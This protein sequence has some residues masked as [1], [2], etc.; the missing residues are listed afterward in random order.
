MNGDGSE[1]VRNGDRA[2][3]ERDG[4]AA[5]LFEHWKIWGAAKC[6]SRRP[7]NATVSGDANQDGNRSHDR[8]AGAGRT[9]F[10]GPDCATKDLR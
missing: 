7:T 1:F 5:A 4:S 3:V 8:L 9:S 2:G 10:I 6:G